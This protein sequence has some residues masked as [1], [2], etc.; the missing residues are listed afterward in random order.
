M[1][2]TICLHDRD[3]IEP[4]LRHDTY[5]HLYEIGDLDDFSWPYTTW[6]THEDQIA[7]LYSGID[8]PVLLALSEQ[9]DTLT[10]LL[11]STLPLLPRKFHAH[12]SGEAERVLSDSYHL[13]TYGRHDKMAL[14]DETASDTTDTSNVIAL[15]E[16]NLPEL[17]TLYRRSYPGN[18]FDPR[19]L[20]TH[21][22]FGIRQDGQLVSVAGVHAYSPRYRVATLGNVTTHPDYRGRGLGT[23]VCA[24]LCQHLRQHVDHIGLNV[25][26]DNAS[27][28]ACYRR[29]GF[30]RITS[31]YEYDCVVKEDIIT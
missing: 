3:V 16:S 30:Q 6:Y 14:L 20:E 7:L 10:D 12:I 19:M 2:G 21:C 11:I 23:A 31:Y 22:Y 15:T 24:R 9:T 17:E 4:M 26:A 29:L 1:T 27:A 25:K 13:H 18:S 8:M 28:I 5:L